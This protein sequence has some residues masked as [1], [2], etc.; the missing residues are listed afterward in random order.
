MT[1]SP[2]DTIVALA[3]AP[4]SALRGIIRLSGPLSFTLACKD[5]QFEEP[6]PEIRRGFYPGHLRV[7]GLTS[8]LPAFLLCAPGPKSATGQDCAELHLLSSPPVLDSVLARL[9]DAGARAAQ[10]GEFTL[11]A[12]LAGKK[13][14]PQAEAVLAVIQARSHSE[15]LQALG[16]LA[17][18]ISQ[19]LHIVRDD[20]LNL[21]A[22]IE[23]GLDFVEEDIQFVS[24]ENLLLRITTALA[25][26]TLIQKQIADRA[27]TQ[28]HFRAALVGK[29]NT[30]KSTL[31]NS[32]IGRNAALVSP[33]AGT[34]RDYLR[35]TLTWAG[36]SLEL[37]DTAGW[38]EIVSTIDEQANSLAA[39]QSRLADLLIWCRSAGDQDLVWPERFA[40]L[41]FIHVHTKCDLQGTT[42]DAISTSAVSGAGI[43]ELRDLLM[44]R[45]RDHGRTGLASSLSRCQHHVNDC[46]KHLRQAH[47]NALYD[48]PAELLALE[49]RLALEQ[50]GQMTGAIYTDDLL[51]RIFS[52][53]C[54][55]K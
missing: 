3:S 43:A 32:L 5:F 20:L 51:D 22:D 49:I 13:D 38:Q 30:G 19:P 42:A 7:A 15:L 36:T 4:G 54:I 16:Q 40:G 23:A 31:F 47:A 34:T 2:D 33:N 18:G 27:S 12:F 9:L 11:R 14:L 52:R 45:A 53:F 44:Q 29:P 35:H 1:F 28:P 24:R 55:G 46:I 6:L 37:I 10:P 25:R 26:I 8:N 48:D 39:H 50:L 17:G 41:A 21:L